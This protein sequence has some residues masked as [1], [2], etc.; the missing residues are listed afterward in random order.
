MRT[1]LLLAA[2]LTFMAVFPGAV[3]AQQALPLG[4]VTRGQVGSAGAAVYT[5]NAESAG[6]LTVAVRGQGGIDLVIV[7]TD[8]LGQALPDGRVDSDLGGDTGAEQ[9]VVTLRSAGEYQV[10]VETFSSGSGSFEI[11][12]SWMS[13]PAVAVAPDPDGLP[14]TGTA[15]TPGTPIDDSI[16][17]AAGDMWD[18]FMVT[19]EGNSVITVVTSA[20]DGDLALEV[21]NEGAFGEAVNRSDQDLQGVAGNESL[22]VQASAGQK[23]YFKVSPVFSQG[24]IAYQIRVGVM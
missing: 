21:F 8:S 24:R 10:R 13:F 20:A 12:A 23:Y 18:W 7:V 3:S 1:R 2:A 9:L 19:A 16:D 17:P 5:F 22:T 14:T 15:L 6:M 11:A 4:S